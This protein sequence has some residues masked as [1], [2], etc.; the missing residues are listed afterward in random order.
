[1]GVN[2][3][4]QGRRN[5]VYGADFLYS[6]STLF[7]NKYFAMG[8]AAA[9]SYTSD[10]TRRTG[11]AQ[12]VFFDFPNDLVDFSTIWERSGKAFNPETGFLRRENYQTLIMDMRI[13]PRPSFLP[14]FQ[15]LVFKPF[16]FNYYIDDET[17]ELQS[18]WSEF[19]PLGFT[20]KSGE[21]F[22]ANYQRRAENLTENFEIH[23]GIVIPL[24]KYWYSRYELQFGTFEGR[25]VAGFLFVQWGDFYNGTRSEWSLRG[26][27][28]IN[29][30]V[31]F[32][33]DF[34][35]NKIILPGGDFNVYEW[36]GRVNLAVSPDLFG[37]VFGQ[38]N[39]DDQDVQLNF[40]INWIPTPGTDFY[41]VAN[42][43]LD[44]SGSSWR[45][46]NTAVL[47]KIIWRFVL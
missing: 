26:I 9:Q 21:F 20:T 39:T 34:T 45:S 10:L 44:T 28:Q 40:R 41:L 42:Q 5:S 15:Q 32:S 38:W 4:E 24:G 31:N 8:G 37:S 46:V 30:H 13:K 11:S 17:H 43:T 12:R 1:M 6:T 35:A 33:S 2:K 7:G 22:E 36:S 29:K 3:L 19:R 16:D 18:F 25:P 47:T 14:W 27:V 23:D